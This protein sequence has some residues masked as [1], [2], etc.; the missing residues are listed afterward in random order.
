MSS[1]DDLAAN[2]AAWTESNAQYTD[3]AAAKAWAQA[4]ITWGMFAVPESE[5]RALGDVAGRD[6]VELGCGTA[7]LSAW[8][9]RAGA[10]PVG[11]DPTPA[12]LET[13]RRVMRE[14]GVEFPLLEAPGEAV[15]L[16]DASFDLAL[17]EHGAATWA[18]RRRWIPEAFR[19]LRP[20]GRLVFL[21][22]T[23]LAHI[24]FRSSRASRSRP[25][26]S[27][28]TSGSGARSGRATRVWSTS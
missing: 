15:P 19:L 23:P 16:P 8:L 28:R 13:A 14:T 21:H 20:G 25:S 3:R 18:D 1:S 11:V 10:R 24:C 22:T 6:V 17:S 27:V 2:V 26:C 5:V 4:E 12:Q 9:A 7:Y